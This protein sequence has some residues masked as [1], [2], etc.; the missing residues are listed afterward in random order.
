MASALRLSQ[1]ALR[2]AAPMRSSAF[3]GLRAY[4]SKTQVCAAPNMLLRLMA[5]SL[6]PSIAVAEGD[7]RRQAARRDRE[8][9]EAP[10]VRTQHL[11]GSAHR[12]HSN[13]H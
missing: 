8:D 1:S 13:S 6:T 10:Q 9:Q 3:T 11:R 12:T 7:V 5:P 2:A 4:S